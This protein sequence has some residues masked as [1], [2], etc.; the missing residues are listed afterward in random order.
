MAAAGHNA[1]CAEVGT[2]SCSF[3][4]WLGVAEM[5]RHTSSHFQQQHHL[6]LLTM[7]MGLET[8]ACSRGR[9]LSIGESLRGRVQMFT[10]ANG[11]VKFLPR[12]LIAPD[13][14]HTEYI[15]ATQISLGYGH[16]V[17]DDMTCTLL[18]ECS[19]VHSTSPLRTAT[20]QMAQLTTIFLSNAS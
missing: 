19:N 15:E 18:L 8:R 17:W 20:A 1:R 2:T 14:I 4:F 10:I 11:Q 3:L 6:V 5:A 12:A 7:I 9:L 16:T 13:P